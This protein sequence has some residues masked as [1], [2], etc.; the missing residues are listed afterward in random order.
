MNHSE[1]IFS[2]IKNDLTEY[3][4]VKFAYFKLSGYEGLAKL[5]SILS[6][7]LVKILLILFLFL[8]VFLSL[9]LFLGEVL[10]SNA[11]GFSIVA[12]IY[13]II[14]GALIYFQKNIKDKIMNSILS[15]LMNMNEED[16]EQEYTN[17][18][19]Y[20]DEEEEER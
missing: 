12:V 7:Q 11:L 18:N 13:L 5:V 2:Q 1:S 20:T 8:F 16:K 6:Y 19:E 14:I 3:V 10:N 4:E 17:D 15:S 9:G